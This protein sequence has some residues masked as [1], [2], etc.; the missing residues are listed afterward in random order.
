MSYKNLKEYCT[1]KYNAV[2]EMNNK[3][4]TCPECKKKTFQLYD[5]RLEKGKCFHPACGL[6]L[7]LNTINYGTDPAIE[8]HERFSK[9]SKE[10]LFTK[11]WQ[12]YDR[13]AYLYAT[14]KRRVSDL[15][16]RLSD[17]G[18]ILKEYDADKETEGLFE[19]LNQQIKEETNEGR[20]EN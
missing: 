1:S 12:G 6:H 10:N 2:V 3:K 19:E 15:A 4:Q 16:L 14:E 7:N 9:F 8:M 20:K 11:D 18:V 5:D 17:V 13:R